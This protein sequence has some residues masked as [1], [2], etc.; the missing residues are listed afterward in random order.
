MKQL[1]FLLCV[2]FGCLI[3]NASPHAFFQY[4]GLTF[5][6]YVDNKASVTGAVDPESIID[7]EIPAVVYFTHDYYGE[8]TTDSYTVMSVAKDAFQNMDNLESIKMPSTITYISYEAFAGLKNLKSVVFSDNITEIGSGV[9]AGCTSLTEITFPT[10]LTK[11]QND[12]GWPRSGAFYGC[13]ELKVVNINDKL[14]VFGGF[15]NCESLEEIN[16]PRSVR[17]IY[18]NALSG[19][20]ALKKVVFNGPVENL[21]REAF[22]GCDNL[23]EVHVASLDDWMGMGMNVSYT[24]KENGNPL[25]FSDLLYIA[26]VPV[27]ELTIPGKFSKIPVEIFYGYKGLTKLTLEEGVDTIQQYAFS[28]CSNLSSLTLP[29]TLKLIDKYAFGYNESLKEIDL[30]ASL[31]MMNAF[32]FNGCNGIEKIRVHALTPQAYDW[33]AFTNETYRDAFLIVPVGTVEAYREAKSWRNFKKISDVTDVTLS[34][35]TKTVRQGDTFTLSVK[36]LPTDAT[37]TGVLWTS[38][39]ESVAT[40]DADGKVTAV[41]PGEAII[42]AVCGN[43]PVECKVTVNAIPVEKVTLDTYEA[44]LK[45]GEKIKLTATVLPENATEKTLTWTTSDES[46]VTVDSEGNVTAVALGEAV[47]TATC[48][49]ISSVCSVSVVPTP[50][51]SVTLNISEAELKVGKSVKLKAT[52]MP[53]DVTDKT[54]IWATSDEAIATV[55]SE[56]NVAAV[57]LG[58]AVI[59]ATCGE[60]SA[61]CNVAVIPTPVESIKLNTKEVYIE[62]GETY[63]LTATVK[64][65]D[66]TDKT[67][68]WVSS[69]EEVFTVDANGT[70]TGV[71]VGRAHVYVYCGDKMTGAN[72]TVIPTEAESI[73]LDI[74]EA[75]M[76]V[77]ETLKIT[78]T[79]LPETTTDKYVVWDSTD[80]RVVKV[81]SEG[82]VTARR[83]GDAEIIAYC[84]NASAVCMVHV[85]E[86][87]AESLTLTPDV[88]D[89]EEGQQFKITATVMPENTT[90]PTVYWSSTNNAIATVDSDGLVTVL[91]PGNCVIIAETGDG[92]DL[93][94]ECH[95]TSNSGIEDILGDSDAEW[96]VYDVKGVLLKK[97]CDVEALKKLAP[98]TYILRSG[99][100]VKKVFIR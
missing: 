57:A 84:G 97:G 12:L 92:T 2:I 86:V 95:I 35:T 99:P 44:K 19:C 74:Y 67:L 9:F 10:N 15:S 8:T 51:E 50:A 22:E 94:A 29:N 25:Q 40:V 38:S 42:T 75:E 70:V 46:I 59:T 17:Q 90:N 7:L 13:T 77:G 43:I 41:Y 16:I 18:N 24:G 88:W 96:D 33:Q 58:E 93:T 11:M 83:I 48:G 1:T 30:P 36:V 87:L 100:T 26:G 85:T 3:G 52:V 45:V 47:I 53:E 4:K 82:N 98:A 56:G 5:E 64:P 14:E 68:T 55:D 6:G 73:E 91:A 65:E 66:A 80:P 23:A 72:V 20:T 89:G 79:V 34:E 32:A 27:T 37:D 21:G 54:V 69:D 49:E 61:T 31:L 78:A 39:D 71:E 28:K 63:A 62:V 60:V 81:D 76:H